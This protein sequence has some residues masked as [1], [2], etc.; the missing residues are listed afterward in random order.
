MGASIFDQPDADADAQYIGVVDATATRFP[1][2]GAHRDEA[3]GDLLAFTCSS[4][5]SG[6]RSVL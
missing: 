4:T 3:R 1:K 6:V 2:A 5:R